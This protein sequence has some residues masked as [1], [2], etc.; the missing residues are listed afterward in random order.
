MNNKNENLSK[1]AF[2]FLL[3]LNYLSL[4]RYLIQFLLNF[5]SNNKIIIKKL[6]FRQIY[7]YK[8]NFD[9]CNLNQLFLKIFILII[10]KKKKKSFK[11][12][13]AGAL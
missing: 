9:N 1:N 8:R 4:D 7:I 10:A 12:H 6:L 13:I 11:N 2:S 5:Y 3:K